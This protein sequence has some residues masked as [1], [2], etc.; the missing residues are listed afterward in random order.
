[1]CNSDLN[2][3]IY[4]DDLAYIHA[5][6]FREFAKQAVGQIVDLL[7]N[8]TFPVNTV[9]DIGCGAGDSSRALIDAGFQVIAVE[10]SVALLEIAQKT[11]PEAKFV[12]DSAFGLDVPPC[13]A[14][15][16]VGE[17][18][19]YHKPGTDAPARLRRF[20]KAVHAALS[21]NGM[22]IFDL[23]VFGKEPLTKRS[24]SMGDDWAVLV[25]VTEDRQSNCLTRDITTFRKNGKQYRRSREK[26]SV[27]V[28]DECEVAK[29]LAEVGFDTQVDSRYGSVQ[30]LSR[31]RAFLATSQST[32]E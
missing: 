4:G 19:T 12:H 10:P 2:S 8:L 14:V 27:H 15:I 31:R 6:G 25:E 1:M 29:W 30:L 26:H 24:W 23:I 32:I 11:A 7:Q 5:S 9:V 3:S 17:P 28:F 20:F 18:L 16:A 21:P 22:L 13:D